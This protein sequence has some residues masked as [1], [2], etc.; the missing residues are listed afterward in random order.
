MQFRP[1]DDDDVRSNQTIQKR[2]P[3]TTA[4]RQRTATAVAATLSALVVLLAVGRVSVAGFSATSETGSGWQTGTVQVSDDDTGSVMFSTAADGLLDGDQSASKCLAV[5]YTGTLTTNIAIRAYASASGA[6]APYLTLTVEEGTGGGAASCTGFNTTSTLYSGTLSGYASTHATF[7]NGAGSWKPTSTGETRTFRF[8]TTVQNVPAAQAKIAN[9]TFTW[10]AATATFTPAALAENTLWLRAKDNTAAT[11]TAVPT[12]SDQSGQTH[13][14]TSVG[15]APTVSAAATPSGGRAITFPGTGG[16]N[17][18]SLGLTSYTTSESGLWPGQY[19]SLAA[20][21]NPSTYWRSNAAWPV[22]LTFQPRQKYAETSY[23]ITPSSA[24]GYAP[25][26]FT[27]RGSNDGTTWNVLDTRI[28]V[29]WPTTAPQT[30]AFANTTEYSHYRLQATATGNGTGSGYAEVA[31]LALL[32]NPK[33]GAASGEMWMVVKSNSTSYTNPAWKFGKSSQDVYY[34]YL[35]SIRDDFG[36]ATSNNFAFT[37]PVTDWRLYRVTTNG[38]TWQM[39]HD[40]VS[41]GTAA[42]QPVVWPQNATLGK[43]EAASYFKGEI[44]E[45]LVRGQ[46][47]TA[48]ETRDLV[49]YFNAEHGLTVPVP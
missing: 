2:A 30:F 28:G 15:T 42:N 11:G 25:K 18:A 14:A 33:P 4:S 26:D 29:T 10:E 36:S 3:V 39:F 24:L 44:A 46:I 49:K 9:A 13:N 38:T 27:L 6:L 35:G 23:R 7:L 47:A 12:W 1:A 48:S 41:R 37:A 34:Q 5:T 16:Y 20:D 43:S 22:H 40:G 8:T 31:E 21:G 19:G 45:V 32:T 17:I